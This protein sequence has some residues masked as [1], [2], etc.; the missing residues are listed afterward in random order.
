MCTPTS[1]PNR[2]CPRNPVPRRTTRP[3]PAV[4]AQDP[5]R[6]LF[7]PSSTAAPPSLFPCLT[8][9]SSFP[10]AHS[11][12]CRCRFSWSRA[13]GGPPTAIFIKVC[14][15][16]HVVFFSSSSSSKALETLVRSI[17]MPHHAK[18]L[19][20]TECQNTCPKSRGVI[21]SQRKYTQETNPTQ[22]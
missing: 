22:T 4:V 1:R 18:P 12:F 13:P 16:R 11:V 3:L 2:L 19:R 10:V 15:T 8:P 6:P 9:T 17:L 20:S 7:L 21:C 5:R 14:G